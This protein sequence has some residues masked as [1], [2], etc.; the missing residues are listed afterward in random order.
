MKQTHI[1]KAAPL[2]A[3][4]KATFAFTAMIT[5][6]SAG[7]QPAAPPA[8][9]SASTSLMD[10]ETLTGD[11]FGAG[12]TWRD[13]G[14]NFTFSLTQ[15]YQGLVSGD[16]SKDWEYGGKLNA[17]LRLD[18]AKLGLWNGFGV[19]AHFELNYGHADENAGGTFLPNN[20]ALLFP[21]AN[22]TLPDLC[23]M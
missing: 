23:S 5:P 7:E 19:N 3:G 12:Q 11:W 15:F 17:F 14:V 2:V 8:P 18:G 21:G 20:V 6:V 1:N 4:L 16:G 9:A 10:R 22:E 13:N